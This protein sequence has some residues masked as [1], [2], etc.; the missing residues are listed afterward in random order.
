M[1]LP[2]EDAPDEEV[3]EQVDALEKEDRSK[4]LPLHPE[5]VSSVPVSTQDT[6]HQT[7]QLSFQGSNAA[8]SAALISAL[9]S[10]SLRS[11][12][13]QVEVLVHAPQDLDV[14]V[15]S[16]VRPDHDEEREERR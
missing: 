14:E 11:S 6:H 3:P 1:H 4:D 16:H 10:S 12:R 8:R 7:I 9:F 15:V 2:D 13:D 5:L